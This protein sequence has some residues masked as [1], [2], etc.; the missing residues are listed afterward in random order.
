MEFARSCAGVRWFYGDG[1]TVSD[2]ANSCMD[3]HVC[4]SNISR[5][6]SFGL[7]AKTVDG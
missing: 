4:V 2:L 3:L 6:F 5:G 7:R 1:F